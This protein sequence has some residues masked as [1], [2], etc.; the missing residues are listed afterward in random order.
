MPNQNYQIIKSQF[1]IVKGLAGH[2][3]LVLKDSFGKVIGELDGLAT[4][5]D[6]K[7]KPIGYLPSDRLIAYSF[8]RSY[9]YDKHQSQVVLFAG[10]KK[11][12]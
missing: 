4:S 8:N 9:L 2:N 5:K 1:P 10:I 11:K 7:I 12:R 3:L 6:G